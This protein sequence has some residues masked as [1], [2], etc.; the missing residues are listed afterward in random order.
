[1]FSVLSAN[2]Q[3]R[4]GQNLKIIHEKYTNNKGEQG[5]REWEF[6]EAMKHNDQLRQ[7]IAESTGRF[8]P[9]SKR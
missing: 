1:M 8:E 5:K 3:K 9:D 4:A 6:E 2:G 7:Y